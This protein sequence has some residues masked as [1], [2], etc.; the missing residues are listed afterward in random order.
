MVEGTLAAR[1]GVAIPR[2]TGRARPCC[3]DRLQG[4]SWIPLNTVP[5][6]VTSPA[7]VAERADAKAVEVHDLRSGGHVVHRYGETAASRALPGFAVD[8]AELFAL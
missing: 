5:L 8:V 3:A 2:A 6:A 7:A 4:R 1:E